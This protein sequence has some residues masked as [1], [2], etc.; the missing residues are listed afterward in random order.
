MLKA[1]DVDAFCLGWTI[2]RQSDFYVGTGTGYILHLTRHEGKSGPSV[3]QPDLGKH[4]MLFH[5]P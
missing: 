3:Y 1:S 4:R 5:S 2:D